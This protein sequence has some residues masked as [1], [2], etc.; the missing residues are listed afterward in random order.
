M[1]VCACGSEVGL[2]Q[3]DWG[4]PFRLYEAVW[5]HK[6]YA[7]NL[8]HA[9]YNVEDVADL[10]VPAGLPLHEPTGRD[11]DNVPS[12]EDSISADEMRRAVVLWAERFRP[13]H[14]LFIQCK[15]DGKCSPAERAELLRIAAL[16]DGLPIL[17]YRDRGVRFRLLNGPGPAQWEPWTPDEIDATTEKE[18]A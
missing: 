4:V 5:V 18:S 7:R 12:D 3:V 13:G 15:A 2:R 8:S 6:D 1:K 10:E 16:I 14:V 11:G 9:A 17:A